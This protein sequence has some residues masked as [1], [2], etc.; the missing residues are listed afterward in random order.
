MD[1]E[2]CDCDFKCENCG[3]GIIKGDECYDD[4]GATY[5]GDCADDV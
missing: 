1:S 4:S 3:C 2:P 5:C